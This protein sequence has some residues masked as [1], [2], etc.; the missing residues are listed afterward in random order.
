MSGD[1]AS[2]SRPADAA[3]PEPAEIPDRLLTS[4]YEFAIGIA[5]TS[6]K[7]KLPLAVPAGLKPFLKVQKLPATAHTKIR[8]AIEGDDA[9]RTA[10]GRAA[11]TAPEVLDELSLLWLTRPDGW[12][13]RAVELVRDVPVGDLAAELR[14]SERRREAAE[15]ATHRVLA[16]VTALRAELERRADVSTSSTQEIERLRAE[17]AV[18]RTE[19]ERHQLALRRA[20]EQVRLAD[21]RT[22]AM[23]AEREAAI[24]RA[25][26]AEGTRD[27]VLASRAAGD[28]GAAQLADE[29]AVLAGAAAVAADLEDQSQAV[30][31]LGLELD[32]LTRRLRELEPRAGSAAGAG[33]D[34]P[35]R[36]P[37][38]GGRGRVPAPRTPIAVPGGLYGDSLAAA[39]H[40][41]RHP[42]AVVI[43]DGYNVAKLRF[44]T[45]GLAQQR[46]RC[47][48]LCEDVARR[49]G[50]NI[51][52]VFDGTN[53]SGIAGTV[54]RLV[55]V[56]YSPEGTIA[57]DV[58]R[59][60]VA[61]L[62]AEVPVVVVTNDQAI[63]ADVRAMGANPVSSD[64]FLELAT[65]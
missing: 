46:E 15:A 18:A 37:G 36:A 17:L 54:R 42:N 29:A 64:R 45:L 2:E 52:V 24:R 62:P 6:V 22:A 5:A 31:R 50:T 28:G 12:Q 56:T 25:E 13:A 48:D 10:I 7:M 41:V 21:E 3:E 53:A 32:R 11:A 59:A 58:I 39:E 20:T 16:E 57:D 9:F 65:R 34:R 14:R 8:A 19:V 61:A 44:P 38:R 47:I 30:R 1:S 33:A 27:A 43:V 4:G 55:R 40:V 51:V 63:V 60:E 49:W 35:A 23:A 26:D